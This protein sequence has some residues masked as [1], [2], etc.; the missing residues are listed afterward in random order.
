MTSAGHCNIIHVFADHVDG[1]V[2]ERGGKLVPFTLTSVIF[3]SVI[4][5]SVIFHEL[6]RRDYCSSRT[7][8]A[9]VYSNI[10]H[11]VNS[12]FLDAELG[13]QIYSKTRMQR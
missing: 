13:K 12:R 7:Y 10:V 4:F 8:N 11:N 3:C 9:L 6:T 5:C 2:G 1:T